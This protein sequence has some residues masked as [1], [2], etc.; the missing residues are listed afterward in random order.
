MIEFAILAGVFAAGVLTGIAL[1]AGW[2]YKQG[3]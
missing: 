3:L 2:L 1:F